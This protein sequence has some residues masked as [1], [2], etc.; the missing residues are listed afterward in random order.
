MSHQ[1]KRPRPTDTLTFSVSESLPA[2]SCDMDGPARG[3]APTDP[4]Q[5]RLPHDSSVLCPPLSVCPS[6]PATSTQPARC[7]EPLWSYGLPAWVRSVPQASQ[8]LKPPQTP[9]N[10]VWGP[11]APSRLHPSTHP[12]LR[13]LPPPPSWPNCPSRLGRGPPLLGPIGPAFRQLV[14]WPFQISRFQMLHLPPSPDTRRPRDVCPC[15]RR[16]HALVPASLPLSL[17][18][19]LHNC[20]TAQLHNLSSCCSPS[21]EVPT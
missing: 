9:L 5:P 3:E 16:V 2:C 18:L 1:T 6:R 13:P 11:R 15:P 4:G 21:V 8:P 14:R 10:V 7:D 12:P 19:L 20:K 17:S